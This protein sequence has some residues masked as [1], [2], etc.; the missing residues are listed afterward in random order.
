M[1]IP[2]HVRYPDLKAAGVVKNRVGLGRLI[3]FHN[4]PVGKLLGPNSRAWTEAEIQAWLD[5][6]RA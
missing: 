6:H 4:F 1:A 2:K 5:S 3:K